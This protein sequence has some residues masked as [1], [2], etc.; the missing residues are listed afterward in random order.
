MVLSSVVMVGHLLIL[1]NLNSLHVYEVEMLNLGQFV[2]INWSYG[3]HTF[4][5]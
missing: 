5:S 3:G 1:T 4:F 2:Y